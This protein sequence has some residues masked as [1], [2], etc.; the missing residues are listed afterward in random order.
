[1]LDLHQSC[2]RAEVV[3]MILWKSQNMRWITAVVDFVKMS[4]IIN[5]LNM[6]ESMKG[7]KYHAQL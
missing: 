3:L 4:I 6:M 7:R 5:V 1:M 2:F